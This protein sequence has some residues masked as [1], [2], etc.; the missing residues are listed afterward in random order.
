M[1]VAEFQKKKKKSSFL[2]CK[3]KIKIGHRRKGIKP[4]NE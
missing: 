3:T 1:E 4:A 2:T